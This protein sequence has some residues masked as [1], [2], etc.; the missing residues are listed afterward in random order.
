MA[1]VNQP[2]SSRCTE[3]RLEWIVL[4]L[5]LL[6]LFLLAISWRDLNRYQNLNNKGHD[7]MK[8]ELIQVLI[9]INLIQ[10]NFSAIPRPPDNHEWY[11]KTLNDTLENAMFYR[12]QIKAKKALDLSCKISMKYDHSRVYTVV[13]L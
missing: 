2:R 11:E 9:L 8:W 5:G 7:I 12:E 13:L 10:L 1:R 3:S 4:G 6:A